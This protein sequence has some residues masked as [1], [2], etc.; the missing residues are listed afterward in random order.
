MSGETCVFWIEVAFN[1]PVRHNFWYKAEV[2]ANGNGEPLVGRRVSAPFGSRKLNGF[3]VREE[4]D[5]PASLQ[6]DAKRIK[7]VARIIDDEPFF[8]QSEIELSR[9][10]TSIYLCSFGEA[11]SAMLPSARRERSLDEAFFPK[12]RGA[13]RAR[14]NLSDEQASAVE[15][16]RAAADS[17]S[18][19]S[20]ASGGQ[21]GK[22][23]Y[24]R[25]ITGS[26]K[27]EV[28]L[29][30]AESIIN[31][32]KSVIYLV[33]EIS[34]THQVVEEVT[35]RFGKRAAVLH[36]GLT[37]S[38]KL[39]QW[40]RIRDGE[41]QIVV[42]ARS[43]VF[44]P[45]KRLGLIIIDEEQ[46]AAYKS[47]STPR[48]HA[49]QV[50]M[51]RAAHEPCVLVMGSAT[52]SLEA[53]AQIKRGAITELPLTRRLAGGKPPSVSIVPL[54]GGGC[55]LS[56][57]LRA[58]ILETKK[59]GRQTVLLLNRRGFSRFFQCKTCGFELKCKNC[60]VPLTWHRSPDRMQCHY[61]GYQMEPPKA[62]PECGSLDV[63]Y[64]G[65]GTEFVESELRSS[66]PDFSIER[67]DADSV[68]E[69]GA[70][71]KILE[72]FRD[73]KTDILL[74]TQMIAKGLNFP[75]VSL[76][77]VILADAALRMPDFRAAER[78]FS[79][80]VQA[81]GRSGRFFPDG[82]VQ[83]QTWNPHAPAIVYA[84]AGDIEGFYSQELEQR[85]ALDFPPCTR[86]IRFLFRGKD[87]E[88]VESS[89]VEAAA[90]LR[91]TLPQG[92]SVLGPAECPLAL[93]AGN[94]RFHII[95]KTKSLKALL[96]AAARF[97]ESWRGPR[98]VYLEAD[99]D[100]VNVM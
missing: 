12:E 96:P 39:M 61:C 95:L 55:A 40:K 48:Y 25:G 13:A 8:G 94:Y 75:G 67:A 4:K 27:T 87:A 1:L 93:I 99:V 86:L 82:K 49:R 31:E 17:L 5:K 59:R 68:K 22:A 60:S 42:G 35:G 88:A 92:A 19:A 80:L 16:I 91:K 56:D 58:S 62:C 37:S 64:L 76:V 84:A 36:S 26:G 18:A 51:Y 63:A 2:P 78:T 21:G 85:R 10:M 52:P 66:F 98:G 70:L 11:L 65:F 20:A 81:A 46:E 53:W 14:H 54:L 3:I 23:F 7:S 32:G 24:L 45:A 34:L 47:G 44:A 83:V 29:S 89:A 73:G 43:A 9:W 28:F 6:I 41:A 15:K 77:G 33:P 38:Q 50:A 69:R 100:P 30:A 57:E 74:G 72:D 71:K 90:L 79:L 97:T